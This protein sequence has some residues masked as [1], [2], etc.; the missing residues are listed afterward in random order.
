MHSNM[1]SSTPQEIAGSNDLSVVQLLSRERLDGFTVKL[2]PNKDADL[3]GRYLYNLAVSQALYPLLHTL[4]VVLRNRIF[5]V[6]SADNPIHPDEPHLYNDYPCWLDADQP[7]LVPDHRLTVR[8]RS[9][10]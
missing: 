4:E 2:G 8:S 5:D 7:L 10:S 3:L 6:V 1:P 9:Q